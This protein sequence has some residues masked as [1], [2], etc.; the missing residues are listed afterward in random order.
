MRERTTKL[1]RPNACPLLTFNT[2]DGSRTA[3]LGH[4][5]MVPEG[6]EDPYYMSGCIEWPTVP[7]HIENF[8]SCTYSFVW[9]DE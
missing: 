6:E 3:C 7:G 9:E 2:T 5:G 4:I 1:E 8:P